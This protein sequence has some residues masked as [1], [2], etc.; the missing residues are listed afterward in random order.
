MNIVVTLYRVPKQYRQY[1]AYIPLRLKA[2]QIYTSRNTV[3]LKPTESISNEFCNNT[4]QYCCQE[5]ST[6]VGTLMY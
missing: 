6:P 2:L 4:I 3:P 1:R 5:Y